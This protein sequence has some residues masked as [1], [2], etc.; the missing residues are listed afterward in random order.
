LARLFISHSSANNAAAI[1]LR[2]WLAEQGWDDVFLDIDPERGLVA[3]Q[4]WQEALKAAA[5]R[6][7]AVLFLVSPAWLRSKWCLAEFLLVKTLNKRIF[8]VIVEAVPLDELPAEMTGEWQL[9]ELVG[10]DRFRIFEVEVLGRPAQVAFREAGLD[11]LRRG[12][13]RA[14][15]DAQSFPWPPRD[16]PNRA[17][18]RG[19]KALE[20]QDASIFFGRDAWI[21]R[22]L[23]RIR[24]LVEGGVEKFLVILGAS[25]SGKSS[26]LRAGLWPRLLRDDLNFLP[27][28]VV[29]PQ[30]AVIGGSSGLAAALSGSF[31]RFGEARSPG[32]IRDALS[33]GTNGF[34]RL[35]DELA[36]R[37]KTRHVAFAE[38]P[39][40][41]VIVLAVDQA[42]E[43]FQLEGGEEAAA[44]FDLLARVLAPVE[45]VAARRL[46]V[47]A[48]MRSDRLE[49]VAERAA[50]RGGQTGTL[51]P[52]ADSAGGVQERYRRASATR[53]RS[54]RPSRDR[55]GADRAADR[56]CPRG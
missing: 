37:A 31:A 41:P 20:P 8:G 45:G 7:E 17:P 19:L 14:G 22:G 34:R 53:D 2:D 15:L 54:G 1:A 49:S 12:L 32:R 46:L 36:E 25:G 33:E 27:L 23:D 42:E 16:E 44:F 24:G 18:Y 47:V 9:C 38:P 3:G 6:C 10:A 52:A 40:D 13:E 50:V 29:R 51:R 30:T 39:A 35:L 11:V 26:F 21:V 5:D 4:R 28:P 48:T 56:R 55:S 43:L